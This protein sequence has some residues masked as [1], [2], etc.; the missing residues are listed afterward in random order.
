MYVI[1]TLDFF[2]EMRNDLN[3]RG[4]VYFLIDSFRN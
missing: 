1:Y 2:S 4:G 3:M